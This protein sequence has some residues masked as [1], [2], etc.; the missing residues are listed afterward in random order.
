MGLPPS[1]GYR[2]LRID[3]DGQQALEQLLAVVQEARHTLDVC[4]F[5]IGHDALGREFSALL[6]QRA[7]A[8][9][10]VR[11]LVDGIGI[12]L[13]GRIDLRSLRAAGVQVQLFVSPLRSM[14]PGRTNLRNHRKLVVADG[15]RAWTG[16][17][18]LA[19]EYF[20][21]DATQLLPKPPWIDL[22]FGFGGALAHQ[23]QQRFDQDWAFA[24]GQARVYTPARGEAG[25]A[26]AGAGPARLIASSPLRDGT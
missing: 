24:T 20:V 9:V 11:L 1:S 4:T 22:S 6:A 12:Y 19:A 15:C 26:A 14:L 7:G 10:R 23:A 13:G 5:L 3:A 21:G 2:D 17:R 18:N 25:C 8:G 16:G